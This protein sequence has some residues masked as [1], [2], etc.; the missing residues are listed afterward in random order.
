MEELLL[1]PLLVVVEIFFEIKFLV[2]F[3]KG[4]LNLAFK[5]E[6]LPEDWAGLR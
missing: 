4:K 1:L 5:L 2:S 3:S 6:A